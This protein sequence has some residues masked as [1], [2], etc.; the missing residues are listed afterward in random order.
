MNCLQPLYCPVLLALHTYSYVPSASASVQTTVHHGAAGTFRAI[1]NVCSAVRSSSPA[2]QTLADAQPDFATGGTVTS[3]PTVAQVVQTSGTA[4]H[5]ATLRIYLERFA[6]DPA[7]HDLH[8]PV[9]LEGLLQ[10][11]L[12]LLDMRRRVGT[13]L[14]RARPDQSA[15]VAGPKLAIRLTRDA[16]YLRVVGRAPVMKSAP[17]MS[18]P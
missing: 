9:V 16:E 1:H 7:D 3:P 4:T 2:R 15:V 5:G 11:T 8:P 18:A 14:R 12:E 6:S 17:R 10:V 13:H